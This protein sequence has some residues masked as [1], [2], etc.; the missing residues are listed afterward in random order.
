MKKTGMKHEVVGLQLPVINMSSLQV[1]YDD[2]RTYA[3]QASV[4]CKLTLWK[5]VHIWLPIITFLRFIAFIIHYE[6]H[7][8]GSVFLVKTFANMHH[9]NVGSSHFKMNSP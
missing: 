1:I 2:H 3:S 6:Q 8:L 5:Y 7:K 4:S 9:G